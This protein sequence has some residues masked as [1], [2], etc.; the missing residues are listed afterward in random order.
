MTAQRGEGDQE[1]LTALRHGPSSTCYRVEL[2]GGTVHYRKVYS[3]LWPW[4]PLAGLLKLNPPPLSAAA[5][6]RNTTR[7][8]ALGLAVPQVLRVHGRWRWERFGLRH[9]SS[10]DLAA[11]PGE[12]LSEALPRLGAQARGPATPSHRRR[13]R[14]ART[15]GQLVARMHAAGIFHRD[16]YLDHLLWDEPGEQLALIDLARARPRWLRRRRWRIKDLAALWASAAAIATRT[17]A[18]AFL[19]AYLGLPPRGR[20]ARL[21][22]RARRLV[23]ATARKAERIRRR[24][25]EA[26]AAAA[27]GPPPPARPAAPARGAAATSRGPAP[28]QP[29]PL[30]VAL[31]A[32]GFDPA[33]GGAE[34]TAARLAQALAARGHTVERIATPPV[35]GKLRRALALARAATQAQARSDL[36]VSLCKAP[37]DVLIPQGG[38][39]LA[40]LGGTLRRHPAA[41]RPL[42]A[43]GR[44]LAPRQWAFLFVERRQYTARPRPWLVAISERVRRDMVQLCGADPAAIALCRHGVELER[45]RPPSAAERHAARAALG[46]EPGE[47]ALL[48]VSHNLALRGLER[49]LR[50]VALAGPHLAPSRAV[51]LA[52]GR[53]RG[54]RHARLASRLGVELRLVG[55]RD[56]VRPLYHAADVLVHP[57]YYDTSSLVILEALACGL[58][59]VTTRAC[60]GAEFLR[61]MEGIVLEDGRAPAPLAQAL[62]RLADP[63][64]R[65]AMARAARATAELYPEEQAL[66]RLLALIERAARARSRALGGTAPITSPHDGA[67]ELAP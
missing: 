16:L 67:H 52:C 29:A 14:L 1:R 20:A 5:E 25:L 37:G 64:R 26:L 19:R 13:R 62:L 36:V 17:D 45:F 49:L 9:T 31:V 46:L 48:L 24:R 44:L 42:L 50:A 27:A 30:R 35:R 53:E 60:G 8:R 51:V 33:R 66:A 21:D 12:P 3:V 61:G 15:L 56:D 38:V 2:P 43:L 22:R 39:H 41:L 28:P 4:L 7:L 11:V 63:A 55:P 40:A 34:A 47:L 32:D 18:L 65:A 54:R 58:P 10:V 57:S 6:A 23:R 59:V